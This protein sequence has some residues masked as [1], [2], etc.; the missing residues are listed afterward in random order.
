MK[1]RNKIGKPLSF[2]L[3]GKHYDV[4]AGGECDVPDRIAYAVARHGLPLEPVKNEPKAVSKAVKLEPKAEQ[5]PE[6]EEPLGLEADDEDL[7][8]KLTRPDPPAKKK[9]GK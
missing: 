1:F 2:D 5:E 7:L 3:G 8:D 6:Q 9:S 4:E